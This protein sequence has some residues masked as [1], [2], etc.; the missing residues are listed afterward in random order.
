VMVS[1]V[2]PM[3]GSGTLLIEA[4]LAATHTAPGL[5]RTRWPFLRWR[6]FDQG[7]WRSVRERA[8]AAQRRDGVTP[9]PRGGGGRPGRQRAAAVPPGG[10]GLP[11]GRAGAGAARGVRGRRRPPDRL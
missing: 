7:L 5:S 9:D 6:D 11:R 8:A 10:Q 4:A 1:L 3:C 2:D